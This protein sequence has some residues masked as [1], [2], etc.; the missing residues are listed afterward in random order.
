MNGST[1]C[2]FVLFEKK[3][4]YDF[5]K[6]ISYHTKK[7]GAKES[8]MQNIRYNV[9]ELPGDESEVRLIYCTMARYDDSWHSIMHRHPHAEL[10]FCLDGR[11]ELQIARER[12]RLS[13]GDFFLINPGVEHTEH[14][15]PDEPLSYIVIG[16]TG[17]R[18]LSE[19][20]SE[21][22]Q[23][24]CLIRGQHNSLEYEPYF[25]DIIREL[26]GK[27]EGYL[28][29]CLNILN[30]LFAKIGR[31]MQVEIASSAPLSSALNCAEIKQLIDERF[32]KPITLEWLAAQAHVSKYHLSHSF[33]KQYAISPIQY[34]NKRRLREAEHLLAHTTHSLSEIGNMIGFSSASYFSQAF[35]RHAG[36]SPSEYRMMKKT[37]TAGSR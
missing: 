27:R 26:D 20:G 18:F 4:K 6:E 8:D 21:G 12:I 15:N 34:L 3:R 37:N 24:Y 33:Q 2:I 5:R 32:A 13:K 7:N 17:V 10:F 1:K 30:I 11:G 9:Q 25:L 23:R 28:S 14:S 29:I 19:N 36:L 35:K 22:L 16:A 31:S